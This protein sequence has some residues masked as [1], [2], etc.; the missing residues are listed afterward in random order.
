MEDDNLIMQTYVK[1][2]FIANTRYNDVISH[3]IYEKGS[4][5]VIV[6]I[7][8]L[9][10]I[11]K[12]TLRLADKLVSRGFKVVLPH[13]FG[14]LGSI[15]IFGNTARLF[16]MRK[17]FQLFKRGRMS[18]VVDWLA[19]LCRHVKE[20]NRVEG[21]GV[22]GMCLTG[23]FAISLMADDSVLAAVASQ[24]SLPAFNNNS[25]Q[26]DRSDI[27]KI[28]AKIDK[29][30]PV[31]ALRFA[32]DPM[33]SAKRFKA[34]DQLLNEPNK[35]RVEFTELPGLGHSVLALN[36]VDKAGHP[37]NLALEKVIHY[38]KSQLYAS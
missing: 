33:C 22:I 7:Q 11:G 32:K 10:G 1:T 4:G 38:F 5:A 20:V 3:D 8:E 34:L 35:Q 13:L 14:P 2:E 15:S 23:N 24:P 6:L 27:D 31:Q 30:H 28:K 9:P 19:A 26:M 36:F 12:S 29:S 17:E 37:T 18:P 16:C 25:F 21:V